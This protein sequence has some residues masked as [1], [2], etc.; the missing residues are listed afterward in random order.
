MTTAAEQIQPIAVIFHDGK[1][2]IPA[3][4]REIMELEREKEDILKLAKLKRWHQNV[5]PLLLAEIQKGH[6]PTCQ[7]KI[8]CANAWGVN[9]ATINSG[10]R[11]KPVFEARVVAMMLIREMGYSFAEVGKLF[12]KDHGTVINACHRFAE[13]MLCKEFAAKVNRVREMVKG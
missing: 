13:M 2:Q 12:A 10:M 9:V 7:I 11:D 4:K 1:P 3:I 6:L 8:A 5:K